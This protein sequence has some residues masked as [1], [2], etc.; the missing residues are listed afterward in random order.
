MNGQLTAKF[1]G[2]PVPPLKAPT[3]ILNIEQIWWLSLK[4]I[5]SRATS[6]KLFRISPP[7]SVYFERFFS[8]RR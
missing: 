7:N 6:G 4:L 2:T 1:S 3:Y 5:F 8:Q